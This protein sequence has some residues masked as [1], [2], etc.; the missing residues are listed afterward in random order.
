MADNGT[1][2]ISLVPSSQM[3]NVPSHLAFLVSQSRSASQY[4]RG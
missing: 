1:R 3:E 4:G 2:L